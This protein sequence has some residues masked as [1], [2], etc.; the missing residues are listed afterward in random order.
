MAMRLAL[1]AGFLARSPTGDARPVLE[2]ARA[3]P[4]FSLVAI[5]IVLNITGSF[6]APAAH[7]G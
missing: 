2:A 6:L 4:A 3:G 7:N 5:S 1:L